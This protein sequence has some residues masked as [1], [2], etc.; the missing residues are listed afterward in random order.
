LRKLLTFETSQTWLAGGSQHIPRKANEVIAAVLLVLRVFAAA[1]LVLRKFVTR[2][3]IACG[4]IKQSNFIDFV[5]SN[6]P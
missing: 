3:I 1:L 4:K 2:S 5:H 6:Q